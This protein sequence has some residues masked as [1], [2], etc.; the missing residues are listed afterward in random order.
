MREEPSTGE[1]NTRSQGSRQSSSAPR[2]QSVL[3]ERNE[4]ARGGHGPDSK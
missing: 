4:Q 1:M 2:V 3:A